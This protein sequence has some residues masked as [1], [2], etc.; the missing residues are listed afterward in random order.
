MTAAISTIVFAVLLVLV[1]LEH[2]RTYN[3]VLTA[4]EKMLQEKKEVTP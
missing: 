3:V 2:L 4:L 1:H